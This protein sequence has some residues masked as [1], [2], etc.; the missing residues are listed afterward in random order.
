MW[1]IFLLRRNEKAHQETKNLPKWQTEFPHKKK[2]KRSNICIEFPEVVTK[3][4]AK[5]SICRK[6]TMSNPQRQIGTSNLKE[7]LRAL[8]SATPQRG[9]DAKSHLETEIYRITI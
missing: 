7:H 4:P 1:H 5:G 8:R 3:L 6:K 9:Y 2:K